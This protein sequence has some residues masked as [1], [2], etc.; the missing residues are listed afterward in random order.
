MPLKFLLL[1]CTTFYQIVSCLLEDRKLPPGKRIDIGGYCLHLVMVGE[2]QAGKPTIVLDHSL[3]GVEGYLL[4]GKLAQLGQVCIYD[5]A[6]YG[7]SDSSPEKRTSDRIV[8]ELDELLTK[9]EVKPPYV[10]VG[11]SFG[12]YNVR[13]YAKRFPQKVVGMVLTD[14]LHEKE[15]LEIPFALQALQYFFISGF[16]MSVFGSM[17]GIVRILKTLGSFELLKGELRKFTPEELEPVKRSFC[18]SQHWLTMGRE[19]INLKTSGEQVKE[20]EEFKDLPIVSIK[21]NS[22]FQPSLWTKLIPLGRA[23]QLREKM[24]RELLKLSTE[25]QQVQASQS[26]HFVWVDEPDIMV[27]A[28]KIILDRLQDSLELDAPHMP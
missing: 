26:S 14:G 19:M 9:A 11:D 23:N 28:V 18:R 2:S 13:L 12:S 20:A 17:L 7:W 15:M 4:Q 27:N 10:L 8:T 24:H 21:A 22:F 3:G 16:L 25:C 1:I 5:R 6:G